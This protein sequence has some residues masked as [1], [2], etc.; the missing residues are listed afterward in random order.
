MIF[1]KIILYNVSKNNVSLKRNCTV[2]FSNDAYTGT[3]QF[4]L[5]ASFVFG[6]DFNNVKNIS[7]LIE[8]KSS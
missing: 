4:K 2:W 6:L 7:E 3:S 1:A 5:L 8:I